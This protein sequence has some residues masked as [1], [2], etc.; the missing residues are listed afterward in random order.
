MVRFGSF[1]MVDV[2][3]IVAEVLDVLGFRMRL[4]SISKAAVLECAVVGKRAIYYVEI[5]HWHCPLASLRELL[6]VST[7]DGSAFSDAP[8]TWGSDPIE[9]QGS[10]ENWRGLGDQINC[11]KAS[12]R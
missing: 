10:P 5:K 7:L 11:H 1:G 8:S 4:M 9:T 3:R 6:E 2:E 12:S